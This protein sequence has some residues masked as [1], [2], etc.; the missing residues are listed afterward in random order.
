MNNSA[1]S[2]F[3]FQLEASASI[4]TRTIEYMRDPATTGR[5]SNQ[6]RIPFIQLLSS[7]TASGKTLILA[8]AVSTIAQHAVPKPV[9]LWLSKATVVVSQTY[10]NLDVGGAY[11]GLLDEFEVRTLADYEVEDLRVSK[12]SLLYF[13][14]VG[15]FNQRH[16]AEGTLNVFKS[17]IDDAALSTWDS[18]KLRSDINGFRRPLIVVYDEAQNLSDQQTDLLLELEPDAFLFATA[19]ARFP[20]KFSVEVIAP[21]KDNGKLKESDLITIVDASRVAA[22]GLVKNELGLIGRRAPMESVLQDLHKAFKEATRDSATQGLHG[23]PKAVY[24]CKTNVNEA[25]GEKD[26]PKKPFR[27]REAPPILIWRHL[28]EK[29]EI[30]PKT[31]AVYCDLKVDK[32]FPLPENFV[33]FNGGDRDY[34][35]FIRGNFRHVIFNQALQEGWD[36]PYVYFAYID[37]TVGSAIRAEQIAGRLLRQPGR[38][39]YPTQRLNTAQIFVRVD[40]KSVFEKVVKEVGQKIQSGAADIKINVTSPDKNVP[41]EFRPKKV[42]TVPVSATVTDLAK[43]PIAKAVESMLDFTVDPGGVNTRGIGLQSKIQRVVG[44]SGSEELIWETYG[45]SATVLARWIFQRELRKYHR[46][47]GGLVLTSDTNGSTSKFDARIGF[48]SKAEEHISAIAAKVSEIYTNEVYLKLR[49]SNPYLV[50]SILVDEAEGI[51]YKNAL[52]AKYDGLNPLEQKFAQA[53]DSLGKTWSRNPTGSGYKIPLIQPGKTSNFF[54]D[55]LVWAKGNVF[56]IDTKGS[57]LHADAA[58]KL[59]NIM[60]ADGLETRIF[61]RFISEGLVNEEGSQPDSSGFTTWTYHANGSPKFTHYD[62][63]RT[64]ARLCLVADL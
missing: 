51:S 8:D 36:D 56:A 29:L 31:I 17:A 18:L 61:I 40:A 20:T 3:D 5:V 27:Q 52:H 28:V 33:L 58:R 4:A 6:R 19:T 41:T 64:A 2:L 21:L 16:R 12:S 50:G 7:I 13:A 37:M 60:P 15:T 53:I 30:D 9:I 46:D 10:A 57:H 32:G 59:Q 43:E 22:S 14:T 34:E 55:F 48:G 1:I 49:A 44:E 39:H 35:L 63:M 62:D 24:V 23:K 45:E 26:S 42:A 11:H 47:A 54:P 25:T 38:R